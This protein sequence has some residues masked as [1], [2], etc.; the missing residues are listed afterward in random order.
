MLD[1]LSNFILNLSLLRLPSLVCC[2]IRLGF[3][4]EPVFNAVK[5]QASILRLTQLI[6]VSLPSGADDKEHCEENVK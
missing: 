5:S 6:P 3:I 2:H 1:F 4:T